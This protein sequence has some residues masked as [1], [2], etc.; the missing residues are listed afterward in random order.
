MPPLV[1]IELRRAVPVG[2]RCVEHGH[3]LVGRSRDRLESQFLVAALVGRQA[4]AAETD[5]ELRG[6]EPGGATQDGEGT[7]AGNYVL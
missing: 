7:P 6:V 2:V 3:T 5:A 1:T 4:H